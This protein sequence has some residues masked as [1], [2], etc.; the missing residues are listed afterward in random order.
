MTQVILSLGAGKI[1]INLFNLFQEISSMLRKDD[2]FIEAE[3][4]KLQLKMDNF[5]DI[6]VK[7]FGHECVTNYIHLW[8]AGHMRY[9]KLKLVSF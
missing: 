6:Y 2:D 1:Y 7:L 5:F 8:G 3:K 9:V 4:K